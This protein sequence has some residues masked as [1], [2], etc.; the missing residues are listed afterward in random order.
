MI[1]VL[2]AAQLADWTATTAPQSRA[3]E[4]AEITAAD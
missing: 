2:T 3:D 1:R 4:P